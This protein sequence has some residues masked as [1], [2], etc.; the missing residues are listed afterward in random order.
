MA[1]PTTPSN[2]KT[3]ALNKAARFNYFI[4][5]TLE[6][7]IELAGAE[8]KSLRL[9]NCSIQESHAGE[10]DGELYLFNA[11]I[12]EYKNAPRHSAFDSKRPR[13]LLVH[14]KQWNKWLGAITRHGMTIVP[15]AIYF[16]SRGRVKLEIGLAKGKKTVDKRQTIKERD[17]NREKARLMKP[18]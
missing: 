1:K 8:V 17:W 18:R 3:I 7:G 2:S 12:P 13:K 6:A 4:E 5:E 11:H 10:M 9:N 14:K 15:L 16:N